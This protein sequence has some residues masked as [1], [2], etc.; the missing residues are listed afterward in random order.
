MAKTMKIDDY[1]AQAAFDSA[2]KLPVPGTFAGLLGGPGRMFKRWREKR[3]HV[4]AM[5]E[6]NQLDDRMLKDIGIDRSGIPRAAR[7]GR[8][9]P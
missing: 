2:A 6:L 4:R 1:A 5:E 8:E 7:Y 3:R 9:L